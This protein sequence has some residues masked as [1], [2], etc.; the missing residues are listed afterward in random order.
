[1]STPRLKT[2][3]LG[4]KDGGLRLLDAAAGMPYFDIV[5]AADRDPEIVEKAAKQYSCEP[6]DDYR[7]LVIGNELDCLFVAAGLYSCI[8]YL[9][10]AVKKK[11][12]ILKTS[13]AARNFDEAAQLATLAKSE[14]IKFAAALSS[15]FCGSFETLSKMV[16]EKKIEQVSLVTAV[17]EYRN[18]NRPAWHFD[19]ELAG[20]GVL[21]RDCYGVI[22]LLIETF[23]MPEQVYS[24]TSGSAS[25]RQQRH[26]KAEDTAVVTMRYANDF[27]INLS[28]TRAEGQ[29]LLSETISCFGKDELLVV[30][31]ENVLLGKR[32]GGEINKSSYEYDETEGIKKVIE[33]FALSILSGDQEQSGDQQGKP[34]KYGIEGQLKNMAV[35]EAAYLSARTGMPE[36]PA[37][38]LAINAV[39]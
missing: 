15:R 16:S 26:Q 29:P 4:L 19:P 18:E 21:L 25:D 9:Q 20:G 8:E 23:G 32:S 30:D 10:T 7:Q 34:F 11:F 12:N 28:A 24:L 37:K 13:P 1:M 14:D 17:C 38:I 36:E 22:D 35:I 33:N 31:R 5:A 6:F 39:E 27:C 3:I 2:G